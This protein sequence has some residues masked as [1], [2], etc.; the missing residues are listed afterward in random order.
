MNKPKQISIER[1]WDSCE[2]ETCGTSYADGYRIFFDE[3]IVAEFE[4]LAHCYNDS[5][6]QE[7]DEFKKI[8]ELLGIEFIDGS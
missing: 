4:P 3:E 7:G 5:S 2:C 1:L 6:C 8:F